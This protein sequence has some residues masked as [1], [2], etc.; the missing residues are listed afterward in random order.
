VVVRFGLRPSANKPKLRDDTI[1]MAASSK[2]SVGV[3]PPKSKTFGE[4]GMFIFPRIF[5]PVSGVLSFKGEKSD[6][7]G[8]EVL[9]F[10]KSLVFKIVPCDGLALVIAL[11]AF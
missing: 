10:T 4:A 1:E 2:E 6:D 3:V 8:A 9:S 7:I 11:G 5:R